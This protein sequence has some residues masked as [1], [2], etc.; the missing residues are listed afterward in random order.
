MVK[1]LLA[2]PAAMVTE[3]GTV[4]LAELL[5]IRATLNPPAPAFVGILTV[6]VAAPPFSAMEVVEP[7]ETV[8]GGA[9]AELV[10]VAVQVLTLAGIVKGAAQ[11]TGVQ[12][13]KFDPPAAVAVKVTFAPLA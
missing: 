7:N 6:P 11:S 2:D 4:A 3:L 12:L 1:V 5:E 8:R 10:K 13:S 9:V